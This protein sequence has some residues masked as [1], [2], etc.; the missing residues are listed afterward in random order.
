MK[1]L[2]AFLIVSVLILTLSACGDNV[3]DNNFSQNK[4]N[5]QPQSS[6]G[7]DLTQSVPSNE[8]SQQ[9]NQAVTITREKALEIAL[10]EVGL[11]QED[12]HDLDIELDRERGVNIWEVDFDYKNMEY[13]YDI[14]AETGSVTRVENERDN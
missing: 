14:N 12:I 5:Q 10:K 1:K 9:S 4:A 8:A 7:F 3:M 6:S 13:S 11:K 2:L